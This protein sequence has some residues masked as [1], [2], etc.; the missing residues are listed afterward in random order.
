MKHF[1]ES[2]TGSGVTLPKNFTHLRVAPRA[3][4]SQRSDGFTAV[5][6]AEIFTE[7]KPRTA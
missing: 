3:L 7:R 5:M 2:A 1:R 4:A 6:V